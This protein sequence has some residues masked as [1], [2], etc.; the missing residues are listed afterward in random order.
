MEM[1]GC[2]PER[3]SSDHSHP[4]PRVPLKQSGLLRGSSR[5]TYCLSS[6]TLPMPALAGDGWAIG[7]AFTIVAAILGSF[8]YRAVATRVRAFVFF[9]AI[10]ASFL[11][12]DF[13]WSRVSF[14][15]MVCAPK[16]SQDGP[17]DDY[18]AVS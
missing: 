7:D 14:V 5:C 9:S 8:C 16:M 10:T 2:G 1:L 13:I 6:C 3:Y 17:G 12:N 18:P 11:T 4:P 15:A